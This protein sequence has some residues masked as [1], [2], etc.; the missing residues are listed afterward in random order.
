MGHHYRSNSRIAGFTNIDTLL[1]GVCVC[2]G[3][4]GGATFSSLEAC[5]S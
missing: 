4:G 2:V 5:T 3:G 1:Y